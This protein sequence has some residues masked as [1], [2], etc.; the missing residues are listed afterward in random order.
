[1]DKNKGGNYGK[2]PNIPQKGTG[3]SQQGGS[4]Q[5]QGF[6]STSNTGVPGKSN[7]PGKSNVEPSKKEGNVEKKE[8]TW[9]AENKAGFGSSTKPDTKLGSM[10]DVGKKEEKNKDISKGTS[11]P[12]AEEEEDVM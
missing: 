11:S 10:P 7:I 2:T 8:D 12:N 5:K 6:G 3:S 1:M 4:S 9:K